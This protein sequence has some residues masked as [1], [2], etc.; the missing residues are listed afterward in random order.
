MQQSDLCKKEIWETDLFQSMESL[1]NS[2]TPGN[3]ELIK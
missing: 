3:D 1:K 2:K